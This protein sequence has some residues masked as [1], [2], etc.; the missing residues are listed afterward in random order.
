MAS[1]TKRPNTR[2][3]SVACVVCSTNFP[4]QPPHPTSLQE[5][6]LTRNHIPV[7]IE[8]DMPQAPCL[9]PMK[10][11]LSYRFDAEKMLQRAH[12]VIPQPAQIQVDQ[13][14]EHFNSI[15]LSAA[16]ETRL[17]SN[18]PWFNGSCHPA[19]KTQLRICKWLR[20]EPAALPI[21]SLFKK[22]WRKTYATERQRCAEYR[23]QQLL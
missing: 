18:R 20:L 3:S 2:V 11:P 22:I 19:R 16:K 8:M 7:A 10:R 15:I 13:F 21:A 12:E 6:K 14:A 1:G 9:N 5:D 23:E 17:Q 4:T